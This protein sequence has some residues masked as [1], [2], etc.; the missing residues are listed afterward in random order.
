MKSGSNLEKVLEAGHFA[1]TA[2]LGPPKGG[3]AGVIR[4]GAGMLKDCC[5]ALN[6]TDNQTAVV[7]MSSIAACGILKQEGVD[8]VL[9]MTCRDRNRLAIQADILG[10]SALGIRNILCLTGD[11]Q[12]FG[13]HPTAKNV[14]DIDSIQLVRMVKNMRDEG[15]F[16]CGEEVKGELPFFIGTAANPFADPYEFRPL[17]LAKKV[18]AGADFIQSQAVFNVEKFRDYMARV[19]DMGLLENMY[20]LAG[21]IPA[22]SAGMIRYMKKYVAGLDIPDE[23]VRRM[24]D[25]EKAR[26]EGVRICV[27][28]INQVRE[29]PG[30]RGVH[31]M[32]VAW[33]SIV[34]RIVEEAGLLPRPVV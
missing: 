6:V 23:L 8:P 12:K 4:H 26:E 25:A 1:V 16:D 11:H 22:K 3:D 34:P 18:K 24:E 30:V 21:V 9:Q 7:R 27:E 33:E 32:A 10:A 31:I 15:K 29:I 2:E 14:H 13:N 20:F 17:R 19:R 5:D 28:I